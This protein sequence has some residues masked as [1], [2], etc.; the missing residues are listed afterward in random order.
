MTV[1]NDHKESMAIDSKLNETVEFYGRRESQDDCHTVQESD[2]QDQITV[3]SKKA[4]CVQIL[5]QNLFIIFLLFGIITGATMG[6]GIRYTHPEIA[7]DPLAIMYLSFPG[8]IFLRMLKSCII[9]LIVSSLISGMASL[10][11]TAAGRIGGLA[12]VYYIISMLLAVI[13]GIIL[14]ATIQPGKKGFDANSIK[15]DK[16]QLT[17]PV[18]AFLDLLRCVRCNHF[19]YTC[20]HAISLDNLY[21]SK[22]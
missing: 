12:A 7:S 5:K 19:T 20:K 11:T 6:A 16:G 8:E 17:E 14:V 1:H 18:D 4:K 22:K 3:L 13:L 21:N 10:P 9:P 15:V 2:V